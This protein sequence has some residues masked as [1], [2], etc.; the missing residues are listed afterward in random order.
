MAALEPDCPVAFFRPAPLWRRVAVY[1]VLGCLAAA[2]V[3]VVMHRWGL[4][5]QRTAVAQA[6]AVGGLG[7]LAVFA[8]LFAWRSALHVNA[9]GIWRRRFFRWDL[10]PWEAFGEGRIQDKP[11]AGAYRYPERPWYW[12]DLDLGFLREPDRH[13]V[14]E[15]VR[16]LRERPDIEVPEEATISLPF[17]RRMRFTPAGIQ[18]WRGSQ[19][20]GPVR[21]WAEV[22]PIQLT[23]VD[24]DRR[25]FNR[26]EFQAPG[27]GPIRL[28]FVHGRPI[29]QGADAEALAAFLHRHV[30]PAL[31]H[32]NALDA[33]PRDWAEYRRRIAQLDQDEAKIR[34]LHRRAAWFV[35]LCA[36]AA[37]F[38]IALRGGPNPLQWNWFEWLGFLMF[39]LI[40]GLNLFAHW[41][42]VLYQGWGLKERRQKLTA[43]G[44]SLP[45]ER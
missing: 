3:V 6:L 28:T 4:L 39:S 13:F 5:P 16:R 11:G 42:V 15:L 18:F 31:L 9:E 44:R 14:T 45:P 24:H 38:L 7:I 26:L 34:K 27:G 37:F 25:D 19:V 17:R 10:W 2:A 20:P 41:V 1:S 23:R 43:W 33:A 12:R 32:V 22:G 8:S 30:P 29:W 35:L 21:A 36:G 40:W